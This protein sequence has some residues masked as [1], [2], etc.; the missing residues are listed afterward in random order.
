MKKKEITEYDANDT[1]EF[2]NINKPKKLE[3]LGIKL[4]KESPTKVISIRLPT[5]LYNNIR[6]Y[7]TNLDIPYQAMIKL[8]L[9]KGMQRE[10]NSEKNSKKKHSRQAG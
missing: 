4:P 8:L 1:T 7:S 2:I 6:A 9:E 3:D 10:R 5:E